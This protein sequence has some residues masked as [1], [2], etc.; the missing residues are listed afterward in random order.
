MSQARPPFCESAM[1]SFLIRP[2][3][4][5]S[6]SGQTSGQRSF[7]RRRRQPI[8]SRRGQALIEFA[9]VAFVLTLLL[10]GILAFGLLLVS[11]NVLQQAADVGAQELARHPFSATGDFQS[12]L[13]DSGLFDEASLIVDSSVD[14]TTLPLINQLLFP[15]YVYD[16]DL[17]QLRYPGAVVTNASSETTVLIPI[18]DTTSTGVDSIVEWQRVVEEIQPVGQSAGPYALDATATEY[19]ALSPGMVA[20]RINFPY[21]SAALVSYVRVDAG[22]NVITSNEVIGTDVT[23]TSVTASDST[24]T[25]A[26]LPSGYSLASPTENHAYGASVNVGEKTWRPA[27]EKRSAI[28]QKERTGWL[29]S[30]RS[31]KNSLLFTSTC[32]SGRLSVFDGLWHL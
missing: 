7:G 31:V 8:A 26:S 4:F 3:L 20:L 17:D 24:M 9:I 23:N 27:A 32:Q 15:L 16:P 22:G 6:G 19:G 12:A 28:C 29:V 11:A 5:H 14:S 1:D 2:K 30:A 10:A 21:Q 18:V 13:T 25:V